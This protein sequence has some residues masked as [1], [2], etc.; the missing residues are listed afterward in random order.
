M[1]TSRALSLSDIFGVFF[2]HSLGRKALC[3]GSGLFDI[4]HMVS[5]FLS[6]LRP[7]RLSLPPTPP[8]SPCMPRRHPRYQPGRLHPRSDME[9]RSQATVV[10]LSLGRRKLKSAGFLARLFSIPV[11]RVVVEEVAGTRLRKH[12]PRPLF[13]FNYLLYN[14]E[15]SPAWC[16]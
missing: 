2:L 15:S 10:N 3:S 8:R 16:R 12:L 11:D 5:H 14:S 6:L 4:R 7:R 1:M 9:A 13:A